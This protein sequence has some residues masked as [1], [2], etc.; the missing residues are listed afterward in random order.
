MLGLGLAVPD[1]VARRVPAVSAQMAA[2][3][4]GDDDAYFDYTDATTMWEDTG[5]TT[6]ATNGETVARVDDQTANANNLLQATGTKEP[7]L[8]VSGS[9]AYLTTDGTDDHLVLDY[10]AA[11]STDCTIAF[12]MKTTDTGGATLSKI[13]AGAT[14]ADLGVYFADGSSSTDIGLTDFYVNGALL[15]T[16]TNTRDDAHTAIATGAWVYIELRNVDLSSWT[17]IV[18]GGA[19]AFAI[20]AVSVAAD[21]SSMAILENATAGDRRLMEQHIRA[22][23]AGQTLWTRVH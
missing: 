16:G 13:G 18:Q 4:T 12:A 19:A 3:F 21:F 6:A 5:A 17:G 20:T 15:D 8:T 2:R 11:M 9:G 22:T 10:S 1:L 23:L 14:N 7:T